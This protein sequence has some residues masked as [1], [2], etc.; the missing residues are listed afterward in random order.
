M[1]AGA[2]FAAHEGSSWPSKSFM[3]NIM[4]DIWYMIY[5]YHIWYM[6]YD[7]WYIIYDIWYDTWYDKYI[8][9]Y[10]YNIL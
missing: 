4:Y 10:K 3:I 8:Y 7:I 1:Y 2:L 6:I 5:D 9:I